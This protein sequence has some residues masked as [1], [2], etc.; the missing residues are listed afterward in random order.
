MKRLLFFPGHRI[1]AY[2]WHRGRFRNVQAF[3]PDEAGR[4][5]FRAWLDASPRTP[6]QLL[7]DVIEEEFHVDRVP[8]VLGRDRAAL[9]KRTAQ[10]HFRSTEFRYVTVQGRETRG[11]RDDRLLIAGLT[12]PEILKVWLGLID[13]AR[14]PLKGVYSLPLIGERLLPQLGAARVPRALVVSQ[15]VP[16]TLRQSYYERGRLRFSRLVPGRYDDAQGYV[17]FL[18]RELDQTLHFLET[19]RFRRRDDPIDV[20]VLA[21]DDTH[22]ALR[23]GLA[24]TDTVT[25]H[26]VPLSRL[27]PRLGIRGGLPG[28]FADAIYAQVLLRQPRPAN[29]YGLPRLRRHFF[30]QRA[31]VG[32]RWATVAL[33]LAAV[34][35]ALGTGLRARAYMRATQQARARASEFRALYQQRLSQLSEFQY[36]AVDV[37]NAVDLLHR[38]A[39]AASANPG[40]MMARIGNVLNGHPHIVLDDFTWQ[41]SGD[42]HLKVDVDQ[43]RPLASGTPG[44]VHGIDTSGKIY[45]YALLQGEVVDFGGSYRRA[46][47]RFDAFVADLRG[48]GQFGHVEAVEAPFDLK[49]DSGVSGDSGVD[50]PG[51]KAQRARFAVL[52]RTGGS[53]G[54]G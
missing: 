23:E 32:L 51:D 42:P 27:A 41:V 37:K 49:P 5:A 15:Q 19:Q 40:S 45:R 33:V 6:V 8:H 13:T 11:R 53:D 20:Y 26:L 25:C 35:L 44:L 4:T 2:E 43:R 29:H 22:E 31:R 36:R 48:S 9:L 50:A 30:V 24:S 17:D 46:I 14:V 10:K 47:Q 39:D 52:V 7:L 12:N 21:G 1:I 54:R 3:E 28:T 18:R 16:S 38:L 34:G